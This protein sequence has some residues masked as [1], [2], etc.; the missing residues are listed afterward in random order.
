MK[1]RTL[2]ILFLAVSLANA[3]NPYEHFGYDNSDMEAKMEVL[4]QNKFMIV[5]EDTTSEISALFFDFNLA[6][7]SIIDRYGI[8]E[9]KQ[10]PEEMQLRWNSIDP[11]T[12]NR[13]YNSPY[14]SMGGNPIFYIDPDGRDYFKNNNNE[15]N[16]FDNDSK[17]FSDTEA[18]STWE[19]IGKEYLSFDG[20]ILKYNFQTGNSEGNY[21]DNSINFNGV[22]GKGKPDGTNWDD[23]VL[24]HITKFD[25][26]I[27]N[28]KKRNEGPI[29]EGLYSINKN[30]IQKIGEQSKLKQFLN[31]F[32]LGSFPGGISSWGI[33]RWW[34]NAESDTE[35]FGRGGF[36]LHGGAIWGSRGCIDLCKNLGDFTK[37][38]L[39]INQ[40]QSKTYL[41]VNYDNNVIRINRQGS[42]WQE[43]QK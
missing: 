12:S 33:N 16:W 8:V 42:V 24:Q 17:G 34:I 18:G 35:T 25:Y 28:Q 38:F 43:F 5:N 26:S 41:K 31:E 6:K 7:V 29:P 9:E 27:E 36:S 19:N 3:K 21:K 39:D 4:R 15:I 2:L 11:L 20:E 30:K 1:T 37:M 13:P 10:I 14:S 23:V 40:N 22:S 32:G